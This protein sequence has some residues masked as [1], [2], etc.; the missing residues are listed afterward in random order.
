MVNVS[1]VIHDNHIFSSVQGI[2]CDYS[3][4]CLIV[5]ALESLEKETA[6]L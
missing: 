5:H 3:I 1:I 2:G 6:A 4:Q